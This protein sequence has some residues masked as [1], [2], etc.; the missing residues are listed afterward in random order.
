MKKIIMIL[1]AVC[2]SACG[3]RP[4]FTGTDTDIYVPPIAGVNGIE[5]RNALNVQF[6]GVHESDAEYTLTVDLD[7]PTTQYKAIEVTGDATWQ[8]VTLTANYT[9][10][11]GDETIVTGRDSASESYTFVRYLVA[12][13]ASYNNAVQN[14]IGVLAQKIGARAIAE[15]QK[16]S[17]QDGDKK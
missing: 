6:G 7:E 13:N 9:L 16:H 15:T 2:V 1:C 3:F 4:M 17:M 11:R 12:A 8:Q 10:T 14:T 5:L